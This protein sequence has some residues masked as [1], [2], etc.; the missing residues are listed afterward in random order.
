MAAPELVVLPE[1]VD[2]GPVGLVVAVR[3]VEA[4]HVHA[5]VRQTEE[6]LA[7]PGGRAWAGG[8]ADFPGYHQSAR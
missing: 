2:N 4:G 8:Q 6:R 7:V 5:L 1:E 3:H